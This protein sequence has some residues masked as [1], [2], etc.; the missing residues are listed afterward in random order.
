MNGNFFVGQGHPRRIS[1][2][3]ALLLLLFFLF[4]SVCQRDYDTVAGGIE[5]GES[6]G[7]AVKS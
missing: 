1:Y 7:R 3:E 5:E 6:E 2:P 4:I